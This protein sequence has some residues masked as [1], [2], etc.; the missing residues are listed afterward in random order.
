MSSSSVSEKVPD[1]RNSEDELV[2]AQIGCALHA[3]QAFA[4]TYSNIMKI[5]PLFKSCFTRTVYHR[6]LCIWKQF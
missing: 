4:K 2:L 6:A 1:L 5:K 3:R